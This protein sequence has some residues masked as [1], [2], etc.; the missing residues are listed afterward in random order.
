MTGDTLIGIFKLVKASILLVVALGAIS[1]LDVKIR[2][3]ALHRITMLSGDAH[4]RML[5]RF[6]N[7]VGI[8]TKG[9]IEMISLGSFFYA[10][11]FATEGIGLLLQKRWAEYFTSIV[12]ASFLPLEIYEIAKRADTL[13]I[14]L[15]AINI[16]VLIYLILR[17]RVRG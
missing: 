13:K 10:A 3:E 7:M 2:A 15:L 6:A 11:L 5:E 8:A 9:R 1:L 16:A 14:G 4:F 17:L 12:T